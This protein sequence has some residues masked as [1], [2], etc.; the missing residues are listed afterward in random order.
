MVGDLNLELNT[1]SLAI[2]EEG[3]RNL[4]KENS[5]VSTRSRYHKGPNKF[6]DYAIVSNDVQV[7]HFGVLQDQVSDHLALL[8]QFD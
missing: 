1:K 6:A 2:L 5:I 8:L 4:I 7:V 3:M